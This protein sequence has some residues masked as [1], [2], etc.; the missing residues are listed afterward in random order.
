MI[1]SELL[2]ELSKQSPG[3]RSEEIERVVDVF[4]D[5]IAKRLPRTLE[6]ILAATLLADVNEFMT[7]RCGDVLMLG[8]D[9]LPDGTRA[10]VH[11]GDTVDLP[12]LQRWPFPIQRFVCAR[13]PGAHTSAT[14][15]G[16][17]RPERTGR[18]PQPCTLRV[19]WTWYERVAPP[20]AEPHALLRRW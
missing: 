20:P 1:R 8:S 16:S 5:E 14:Q 11:A 12:G 17:I 18:A 19:E 3:M 9:C 7:L 13:R 10:L 4:F 6:L 2:Q 15:K